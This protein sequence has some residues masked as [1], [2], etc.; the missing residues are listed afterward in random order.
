M[1]RAIVRVLAPLIAILAIWE[2]VI[3]ISGL[4]D[5]V[6]PRPQQVIQVLLHDRAV[7]LQ[8]LSSTLFV[9]LV[10]YVIANLVAILLSIL[11]LYY[12]ASDQVV[13]PASIWIRNIPFVALAPILL[14]I[15]GDNPMAKILVVVLACFFPVLVNTS[16]GLWSVDQVVLDR[17]RILH[18]SEWQVFWRVRLFYALDLFMA[19]QK[20]VITMS[21]IVA[22]AA[23]W[24][25][26]TTGLGYLLNRYLM[27]Y[28]G[29]GVYAVSILAATVSIVL[30]TLV[31]KAEVLLL[32]WKHDSS[33]GSR[34]S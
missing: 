26:S 5:F 9:S 32:P 13:M 21:V 15:L 1:G 20:I 8:N 12:P 31:Q 28:R 2:G 22:I 23:E 3:V 34:G 25:T 18:A 30:F 4:P 27:Q 24:L 17:M 14:L 10:G 16:Q 7:I 11:L 29:G 19:A 33:S 6:L